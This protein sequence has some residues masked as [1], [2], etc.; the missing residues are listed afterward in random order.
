L[1][2][3]VAAVLI[4]NAIN[5]AASYTIYTIPEGSGVGSIVPLFELS[6]MLQYATFLTTIVINIIWLEDKIDEAFYSFFRNIE[7]DRAKKHEVIG[8]FG[9]NAKLRR[10][11]GILLIVCGVLMLTAVILY[12]MSHI[13][14]YPILRN[15]LFRNSRIHGTYIFAYFMQACLGVYMVIEGLS[16]ITYYWKVV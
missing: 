10:N 4:L 11:Y 5:T 12:V 2:V 8:R 14:L 6:L 13:E 9:E 16:N 1:L 15:P 3:A 7:P